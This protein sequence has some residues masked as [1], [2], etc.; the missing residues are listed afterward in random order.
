M[1]CAHGETE[2]PVP[3]VTRNPQPTQVAELLELPPE[4]ARDLLGTA[5]RDGYRPGRPGVAGSSE[6]AAFSQ[7]LTLWRCFELFAR[8]EHDE[9]VRFLSHHL[10]EQEQEEGRKYILRPPGRPVLPDFEPVER[11]RLEATL[12]DAEQRA[13]L[14]GLLLP[15]GYQPGDENLAGIAGPELMQWM[16]SNREFAAHFFDVLAEEDFTPLVVRHLREMR[17]SDPKALEEFPNLALAIAVVYDQAPPRNWPHHQ[18][19]PGLIPAQEGEVTDRFEFWVEAARGGRLMTDLKALG[20]DH[21]KFIVDGLVADS[22]LQWAAANVR[23]PR[24]NF[25]RVFSSIRY[26]HPRLR[27]G[28][29]GW[30]HETYTLEEIQRRGGICVDQAYFA[31]LAGKARGLPTLFFVGQGAD[32]GHAWFGYLRGADRWDLDC[33]RYENQNYATGEALDPQTWQPIS[34]HELR[35]L[36]MRFRNTPAY[37]A[38]VR[39][40]LMSRVFL[41]GNDTAQAMAAAASALAVS[42]ENPDAWDIKAQA[43]EADGAAPETLAEHFEAAVRQFPANRDLRFTYQR[44]HARQLRAAG[45]PEEAERLERQMMAANRR[46]RSDLSV[47]AGADQL[48]Q[49]VDAGDMDAALAEYRTLMT[50]LGRSGGGNLYY[51]VVYPLTMAMLDAG[52]RRGAQ[53][54]VDLARRTLRP[55]RNG[56][57]DQELNDLADAVREAP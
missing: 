32:G 1:V 45:N 25:G 6:N 28:V 11:T 39:D 37:R 17:E 44:E 19:D 4:Q 14:L 12:G 27:Q 33:G 42:A 23:A 53:R 8:N 48:F 15:E 41:E 21:I 9:L 56:I 43:L 3:E 24:S 7:W 5:L 29:F 36:A 10:F 34:D 52:D 55:E 50:R 51:E 16:V 47:I 38:S 22:E 26:D 18:V 13:K 46:L 40:I 31:M 2:V 57:L 30:P 49:R 54:V 20:A 35:F